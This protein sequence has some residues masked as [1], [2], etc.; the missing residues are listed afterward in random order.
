MYRNERA[1]GDVALL[2]GAWPGLVAACGGDPKAVSEGNFAKALPAFSTSGV[3][4]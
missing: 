4:C 2:Q 3:K 1:V